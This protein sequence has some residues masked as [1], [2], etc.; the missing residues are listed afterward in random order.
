MATT[1]SQ[2]SD[3][4][5]VLIVKAPRL[6]LDFLYA[7]IEFSLKHAKTIGKYCYCY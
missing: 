1:A 3:I 4:K 5:F 7:L 2:S 6:S